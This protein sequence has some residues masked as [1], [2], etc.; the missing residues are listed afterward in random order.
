MLFLWQPFYSQLFADYSHRL[1]FTKSA[2]SCLQTLLLLC[3]LTTAPIQLFAALP[4]ICWIATSYWTFFGFAARCL[5]FCQ[6]FAQYTAS[7]FLFASCLLL[8][9][10]FADC[11]VSWWFPC[12][13]CCIY[14]LQAICCIASCLRT[15]LPAACHCW[16]LLACLSM[17]PAECGLYF[18]SCLLAACCQL[19]YLLTIF[20]QLWADWCCQLFNICCWVCCQTFPI[21]TT[22]CKLFVEY[23]CQ[24]VVWYL[25]FVC[26]RLLAISSLQFVPQLLVV[27]F[28]AACC[29]MFVHCHCL[30]PVTGWLCPDD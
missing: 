24:L 4:S 8:Y 29:Q 13:T 2:A 5:L 30:V 22:R 12:C 26:S 20:C 7:Y 21:M 18:P 14:M 28:F 6:Q 19:W 3:Y 11:L 9:Q 17:L 23:Y 27:C 10:Q 15:L 25:L 16:L 1:L